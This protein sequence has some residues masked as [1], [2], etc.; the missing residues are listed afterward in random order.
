MRRVKKFL[1]HLFLPHKSNK[2]R[3]KILHHTSIFTIAAI[4]FAANFVLSQFKT[5]FPQILG[6][7]INISTQDL[8]NLTNAE[9]AKEGL[10]ALTYNDKLATAARAKATDMF[11]DDYWAH[12]SPKTGKTPWVFIQDAGYTYTY[13]GENLARGF[14]SAQD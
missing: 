9:R 1:K 5:N 7:A 3:A 2:H 14:T 4:I 12:I 13:A 11:A 10:S 8:L 6:A